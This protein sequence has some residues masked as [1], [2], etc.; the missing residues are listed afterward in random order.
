MMLEGRI[1]REKIGN[2]FCNAVD[3]G[4]KFRNQLGSESRIIGQLDG[5]TSEFCE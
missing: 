5:V 2:L 3:H 4:F 1:L